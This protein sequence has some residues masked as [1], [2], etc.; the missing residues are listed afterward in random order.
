MHYILIIIDYYLNYMII[1]F[2][3]YYIRSFQDARIKF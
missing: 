1:L 3:I 2:L